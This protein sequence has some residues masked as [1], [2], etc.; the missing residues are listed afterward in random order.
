MERKLVGS[1]DQ[2]TSSTRFLLF[3]E[4][5]NPVACHQ[6]SLERTYPH[7]GYIAE[8]S[9]FCW[10]IDGLR[11]ILWTWLIQLMNVLPRY[12]MLV[13]FSSL[14]RLTCCACC[15]EVMTSYKSVD[16][17]SVGI[18]NQRETTVVWDKKTGQPLDRAI[19]N[20]FLLHACA[21]SCS[22][23]C[24]T[25]TQDFCDKLEQKTGSKDYFRP[26]CGLPINPYFR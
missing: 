22:V 8:H 6:V 12:M 18:T 20:L 2:G 25:R 11:L 23:W 15:V 9:F 4:A 21:L 1:I 7:P 24:D 5:G 14:C 26:S 16:I 17:I 19:G 10:W 3:D 13:V